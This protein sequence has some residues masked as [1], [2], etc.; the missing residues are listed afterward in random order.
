[1]KKLY[2]LLVLVGL[3]TTSCDELMPTIAGASLFTESTPQIIVPESS[4]EVYRSAEVW[5]Q[6]GGH[7]MTSGM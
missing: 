3:L 7:I 6:Y 1:M 5:S 2:G 4:V